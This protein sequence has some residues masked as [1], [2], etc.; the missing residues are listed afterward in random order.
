[1]TPA[2]EAEA[3]QK[4][5]ATRELG[6]NA[7]RARAGRPVRP[8]APVITPARAAAAK[9]RLAAVRRPPA[10]YDEDL[11]NKIAAESEDI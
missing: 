6:R 7:L 3:D 5:A 10:G 2:E 8:F 4:A 1:M 11:Q 9:A